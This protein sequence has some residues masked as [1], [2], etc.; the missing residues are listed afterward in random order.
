MKEWIPSHRRIEKPNSSLI[1]MVCL[2]VCHL[3]AQFNQSVSTTLTYP[4]F[5]LRSSMQLKNSLDCAIICKD[6][7][8]K[9][10]VIYNNSCSFAVDLSLSFK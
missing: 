8:D 5:I 9:I 6:M 2:Y 3:A 4:Y 10:H 1:E 7:A